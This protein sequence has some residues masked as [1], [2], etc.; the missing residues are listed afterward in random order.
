[1]GT[2][3][4][5]KG[6]FIRQPVRNKFDFNENCSKRFYTFIYI[7]IVIYADEICLFVY[8]R[9]KVYIQMSMFYMLL[10]YVI[11]TLN[12]AIMKCNEI[13]HTD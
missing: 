13:K 7:C 6:T 11:L 9:I 5:H 2:R 3:F 4:L 12:Y 1:M 10:K 8:L